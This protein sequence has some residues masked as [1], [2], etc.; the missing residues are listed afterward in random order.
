MYHICP[1]YTLYQI[2]ILT[3]IRDLTKR[4]PAGLLCLYL[5]LVCF[6]SLF[7]I[8][9][10]VLR[11]HVTI[12]NQKC[13]CKNGQNCHEQQILEEELQQLPRAQFFLFDEQIILSIAFLTVYS[14]IQDYACSHTVSMY[15]KGQIRVFLFA[16]ARYNRF[17]RYFEILEIICL[18]F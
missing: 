10:G 17:C 6:F 3:I 5:S 7:R 4:K 15:S 16:V 2:K 14:L 8:F 11:L 9:L 18:L 12:L 13:C 1:T